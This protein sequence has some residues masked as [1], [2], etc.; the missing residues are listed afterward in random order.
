VLL[1][2]PVLFGILKSW[3]HA[4]QLPHACAS[5]LGVQYL[6]CPR[7]QRLLQLGQLLLQMLRRT[8]ARHTLGLQRRL[9]D[10]NQRHKHQ[11]QHVHQP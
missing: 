9:Q 1:L 4:A 7:T 8:T 10:G 5:Q 2:S 6:G 11:H 3:R